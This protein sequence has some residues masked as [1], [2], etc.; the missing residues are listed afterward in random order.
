MNPKD[1]AF[2]YKSMG[3][4]WI[5]LDGEE[6]HEFETEDAARRFLDKLYKHHG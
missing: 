3:G 2:I 1:T 4:K 5:V 6:K